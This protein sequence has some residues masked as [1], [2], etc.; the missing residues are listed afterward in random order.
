MADVQVD[1][2]SLDY[3]RYLIEDS[4]MR[5]QA[6]AEIAGS[7][8]TG[9]GN[10]AGRPQLRV[11]LENAIG[12]VLRNVR[13]N[14]ASAEA[15]KV[16]LADIV[17]RF[18][19]LDA[20]LGKGWDADAGSDIQIVLRNIESGLEG[21]G[22]AIDRA[23]TDAGTT[24]GEIDPTLDAARRIAQTVSAYGD[25]VDSHARA[26]N[27]LIDDIVRA[28][29]RLDAAADSLST[30]AQEQECRGGRH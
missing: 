28:H 5:Y 21:K 18:A 27:D 12:E 22:R 4:Y 15:V 19:E 2:E 13:L 24:A 29:A 16:R 10:P 23:K 14:R 1:Q 8:E 25:A 3:A 26:A 17:T 20:S 9:V 6:Q 11:A 7:A 30:G